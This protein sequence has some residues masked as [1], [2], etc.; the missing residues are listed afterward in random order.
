MG[1]PLNTVLIWRN[2]PSSA[3]EEMRIRPRKGNV[4]IFVNR[5]ALA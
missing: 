2:V 5:F 3:V 4:T 1:N